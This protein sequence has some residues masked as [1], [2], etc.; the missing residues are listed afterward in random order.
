M[1]FSLRPCPI[2]V[3]GPFRPDMLTAERQRSSVKRRPPVW[4]CP[5]ER[6]A[7]AE[8]VPPPEAHARLRGGTDRP[9][10][11]ADGTDSDF[12]TL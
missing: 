3:G 1:R 12:L 6:E 10:S 4:G 2:E 8:P 7:G 11:A 9:E 5:Q